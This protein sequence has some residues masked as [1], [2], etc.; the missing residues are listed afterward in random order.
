M[1]LKKNYE[2]NRE[3]A[4]EQ[5]CRYMDHLGVAEDWLVV[6]APDLAVGF[7]SRQIFS[8]CFRSAMAT[9]SARLDAPILAKVALR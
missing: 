4:Y 9:A 7:Q 5:V 3:K 2:K 1:K 8:R 6:F